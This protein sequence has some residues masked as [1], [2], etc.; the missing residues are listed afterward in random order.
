MPI[1]LLHYGQALAQGPIEEVLITGSYLKS[2]ADDEASPVEIIDSDYIANSGAF[3]VGELTAKLS[4]NSG[5]ENQ[6]DSF[7]SGE[8]QGTSNVNL[9]GLG[10]SSTLV[11]ING[12]RQTIAATRANDGSVFVD[13]STIPVAALERIEILKEGATA[14]YGSDAVAGVVNFI[15]RKDFDG[16]EVSGGYQT[17]SEDA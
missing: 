3:T 5:S 13:T 16:F 9:R 6:A 7:T 4:V 11:L 17:T 12:K 10:L 1:T 8:T 15:L 14:A 2:T